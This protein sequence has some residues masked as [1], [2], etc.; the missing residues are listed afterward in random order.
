MTIAEACLFGLGIV[1]RDATPA[2]IAFELSGEY[3]RRQVKGGLS[4]LASRHPP[5]AEVVTRGSPG[6]RGTPGVWRLTAAGRAWLDAECGGDDEP[7]RAPCGVGW[8]A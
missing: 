2:E 5:M 3:T 1:G 8:P 7:A 4:T 6:W